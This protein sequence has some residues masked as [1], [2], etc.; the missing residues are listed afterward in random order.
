M[1]TTDRDEFGRFKPGC[2]GNP[3]GRPQ[4]GVGLA[5][6]IR[7]ELDQADAEGRTAAQ[8]I[9]RTLVAMAADGDLRA[10]GIVCDRVEGR[11]RTAAEDASPTKRIE[12]K[13]MEF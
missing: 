5:E 3:S 7:A 2:S 1:H 13:P 11:P 4:G 9:A 10:I 6:A 8:R 12:F